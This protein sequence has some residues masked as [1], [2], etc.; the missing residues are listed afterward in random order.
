MT[1]ALC[2]L[3]KPLVNSHI[4]PEFLYQ[5]LYDNLHRFHSM[6]TAP[7][8]KNNLLQKGTRERLLCGGCEQHLS[9]L[10]RYASQV[11]FGGI[12]LKGHREG[13]KIYITNLDYTKFKLFQLSILRRA[14]VSAKRE[15][16]QVQLGP[17]AERLRAMLL[18]GDP[19]SRQDY[20]TLMFM[21][22]DEGQP[23]RG[24]IVAPSWAR[25]DGH[26]CY[27]FIFG[28]MVWI[29]LSS[30]HKLPPVVLDSCLK[31]EGS[32]VIELHDWQQM[33]FFT[34]TVH[35]LAGLGKLAGQ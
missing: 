1:C 26:K 9:V 23:V 27:R 11:L 15:F 22:L 2:Q 19:G 7:K 17:H 35:K 12:P 34:D 28:G 18:A 13:P 8:A 16:R 4:I 30:R 20:P 21:L 25:L 10:E 5:E 32:C 14:G 33:K 29:Q 6:S 3:D 24:L 31:E